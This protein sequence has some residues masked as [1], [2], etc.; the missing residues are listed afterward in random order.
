MILQHT[1]INTI[2]ENE[3]LIISI[4]YTDNYSDKPLTTD[5]D[6]NDNNN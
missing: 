4:S 3:S 5:N 6:N 2:S 1:S